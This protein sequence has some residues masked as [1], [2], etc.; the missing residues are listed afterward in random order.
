MSKSPHII[1]HFQVP[2]DTDLWNAFR[3]GDREAFELMYEIHVDALYS[4]GFSFTRD[5]YLVKECIQDLFV[6]IWIKRANLGETNNI[7]FYL[8][9][10]LRRKLSKNVR[11]RERW[12][13]D[14]DSKKIDYILSGQA[15]KKFFDPVNKEEPEKRLHLE[16]DELPPR[17][18]EAL[19]HLYFEKFS[20]EETASIMHVNIKTVYN[21]AW[22]AIEQLR[23]AYSTRRK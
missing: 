5:D 9:R 20:Y 8:F 7:R 17:Q 23:K 3:S 4:Y 12:M 16:L 10:S 11:I 19:Y 15:L 1:S 2:E 18:R 22:R 13:S 21:L 6:D 14:P